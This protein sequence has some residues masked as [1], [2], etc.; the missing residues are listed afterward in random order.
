MMVVI[1][2]HFQFLV[3]HT[4]IHLININWPSLCLLQKH[5]SSYPTTCLIGSCSK[6]HV[7]QHSP[8]AITLSIHQSSSSCR[9][10]SCHLEK[11]F[12]QLDFLFPSQR[13]HFKWRV[14]PIWLLTSW[15][16][17]L[18]RS[19]QTRI[20]LSNM[21][22]QAIWDPYAQLLILWWLSSWMAPLCFLFTYSNVIINVGIT[23]DRKLCSGVR[24]IPSKEGHTS[25]ACTLKFFF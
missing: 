7:K 9:G 21:R 16:N 4:W 18:N 24:V 3:H 11:W 1:S 22:H 15:H 25:S 8:I 23:D 20:L 5:I 10:Q 13:A 6:S 19:C 2:L 12:P 17:F 14:F